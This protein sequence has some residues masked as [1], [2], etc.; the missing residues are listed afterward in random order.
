M[1]IGELA[2]IAKCSAETIRF[3]EKEGLESIDPEV[4]SRCL[5]IKDIILIVPGGGSCYGTNQH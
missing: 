3:Y 2:K 1:K 5:M 4:T